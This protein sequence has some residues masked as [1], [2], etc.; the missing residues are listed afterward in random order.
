[1]ELELF[2]EQ[3]SLNLKQ[4]IRM[5]DEGS[6]KQSLQNI[7]N[8]GAEM[9]ALRKLHQEVVAA[10]TPPPQ[11]YI[12]DQERAARPIT[13]LNANELM[14]EVYRGSGHTKDLSWED[15]ERGRRMYYGAKK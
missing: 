8:A 12:T 5:G 11:R 13:A 10:E 14:E 3:E 7:A 6:A 9:D 4:Y 15:I 2:A 1:M